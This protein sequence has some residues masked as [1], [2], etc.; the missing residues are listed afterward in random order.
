MRRLVLVP[1]LL[2][3]LAGCSNLGDLFSARADVA[4]TAGGQEL[5]ASR[6]ADIL[7]TIRGTAA[8]VETAEFV[9]NLWVDLTLFAQT[10]AEKGTFPVDSS[11]VRRAMWPQITEQRIGALR[12]AMLASRPATPESAVDSVWSQGDIRLFQHILITPAGPTPA[13]T[14]AARR[15]AEQVLARVRRGTSFASQAEA[16]NPDATRQDGGY[17]PPSPR[18]A[19]VPA[20]DSAAWALEPGA[21]SDVVQTDFGFHLIRRPPLEE[22]RSRFY[23]FASGLEGARADSSYFAAL[24]SSN[25]LKVRDNAPAGIK[26]AIM[27]L[28]GSLKSSRALVDL[29]SGNLTVGQ[30]AKWMTALQPGQL[31]QVSIQPDSNLV[32]FATAIAQQELLLRQAD[33]ANVQLPEGTWAAIQLAMNAGT[34][35][36]INAMQLNAPEVS[37]TSNPLSDR[38]A[39]AAAKVETY[40]DNLLTGAAQYQPLP[41]VLGIVMREDRGG[42]INRAGLARAVEL[43][44]AK[45]R[46]DSA[47]QAGQ[48][49]APPAGP[50]QP[51]PGG[52]PVPQGQ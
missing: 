22:V 4:A 2:L 33:S 40:F 46:A 36:M 10:V 34:T 45:A 37:D 35:Q 21:L 51:A 27:D 20:F 1:V 50:I 38:K 9:S 42:K 44:I 12:E 23:E 25:D 15:D 52:P 6:V 16:R 24:T 41:G 3:S 39:A 7:A 8:D 49:A 5:P 31:Q 11:L 19:F 43:A 30:F 29:K 47:A 17:L 32:R 48:P 26:A 14:A 13:D 18:G 28:Q